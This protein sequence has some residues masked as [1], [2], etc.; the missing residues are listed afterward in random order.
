M[1]RWL[2][3][4]YLSLSSSSPLRCDSSF[5][6][7]ALS[8]LSSPES[9][10]N[11]GERETGGAYD[12]GAEDQSVGAECGT[13]CECCLAFLSRRRTYGPCSSEGITRQ[14]LQRSQSY[15]SVSLCVRRMWQRCR[16]LSMLPSQRSGMPLLSPQQRRTAVMD[17][18]KAVGAAG[19]CMGSS[20]LVIQRCSPTEVGEGA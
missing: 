7:S 4:G 14:Q 3:S 12:H 11:S 16:D 10:R 2:P 19:V 20:L 15:L 17:K 1:R 13:S 18:D 6:S 5:P 9:V 8:P